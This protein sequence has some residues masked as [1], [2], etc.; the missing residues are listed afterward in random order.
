MSLFQPTNIY[1][2]ILNG[3]A[4]GTV[5]A[6]DDLTITWQ[7]N[8]TSQMTGYEFVV[9]KRG[10]NNVAYETGGYTTEGC[11]VY[12]RDN[13]G[14]VIPF[15]V[16]IPVSSLS[17]YENGSNYE[18][19]LEM[20]WGEIEEGGEPLEGYYVQAPTVVFQARKLPTFSTV[21]GY[22]NT[23]TS[24]EWTFDFLKFSTANIRYFRWIL[25]INDG[26]TSNPVAGQTIYDT[27]KIYQ[28]GDMTMYYEGFINGVEYC[29][30]CI[31]CDKYGREVVSDLYPFTCTYTQQE[32]DFPITVSAL[33]TGSAI[34]VEWEGAN[35]MYGRPSGNYQII[36]NDI[37]FLPTTNDSVT[38]D[39]VGSRPISFPTP[40][41]VVYKGK[42]L[43]KDA[44]LWE[45][46][47]ESGDPFTLAYTVANRTLT[48]THGS[49]VKTHRI[50]DYESTIS[51]ILLFPDNDIDNPMLH[52]REDYMIDGLYPSETLYPGED[53]YP[54]DSTGSAILRYSYNLVGDTTGA[55]S[56]ITTY[57]VQEC[58]YIQVW[59]SSA[60]LVADG[61]LY[62]EVIQNG[63]YVP[64]I[65]DGVMFNATFE[66]GLNAGSLHYGSYQFAGW[67]IYRQEAGTGIS[68]EIAELPIEAY[69]FNDYTA[70][71]DGTQYI[72]DIAPIFVDQGGN[73]TN[74][75][76]MTSGNPFGILNPNYTILDTVFNPDIK[77]YQLKAEYHFG[78]NV[79]TGDI[80][81]NNS[82]NI[83]Q[84]FTRYPTVQLSCQNYMSGQ[85]S[86]LIGTVA[87]DENGQ[88][89]YSDT[90]TMR[91][92]IFNLSTTNDTLFL[93]TR[94]G[95]IFEIRIAN[96]IQV[97]IMDETYAQAQEA[98][99]NWVQVDDSVDDYVLSYE[100]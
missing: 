51:T 50:T 21:S 1:P 29:V 24:R 43:K 65:D 61:T 34:H 42:L 12:G 5:D 39:S 60:T 86:S 17:Y 64:Q 48:F 91:D 96:P 19:D 87:V 37:L 28:S 92:A 30:Q 77:C 97:S 57:G 15:S 49:T 58:D 75:V 11:P 68:R 9:R 14:N 74:G 81:N 3:D 44:V 26:T 85:V 76:A 16:T 53:V 56:G 13:L 8:G 72:Y 27:G 100:S 73:F 47:T 10:T 66:N 20:T 94:K 90:R 95:D 32:L 78:K 79:K 83:L 70:R 55:F 62:N 23:I 93:K 59:Q 54:S 33:T 35:Y 22:S 69:T 80:S 4:E 98:A 45:I 82:P 38:W 7:I 18:I 71:T 25:S 40:W 31:A 84:N 41:T 89:T 36:D 88:V 46:T 6:T 67:A 52:V 2:N 63:N 99:I